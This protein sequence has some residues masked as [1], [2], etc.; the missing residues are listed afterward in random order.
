[1]DKATTVRISV[2]AREILRQ[3]ADEEEKSMTAALEEMLERERRRR[4]LERANQAYALL[5]ADKKAWREWRQ[6]LAVWDTTLA[7]GLEKD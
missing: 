4:L 5:R 1:M 6:E 2:H 3:I 7:D